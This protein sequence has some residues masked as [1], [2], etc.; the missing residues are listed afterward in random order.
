MATTTVF[1]LQSVR[2]CKVDGDGVDHW[3]EDIENLSGDVTQW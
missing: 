2:L 1:Y 3:N